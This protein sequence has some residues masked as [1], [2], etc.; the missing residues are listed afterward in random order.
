MIVT[1]T[2]TKTPGRPVITRTYHINGPQRSTVES[3]WQYLV[4]KGVVKSFKISD[5]EVAR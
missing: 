3:F 1:E 5:S 2:Q 4:N